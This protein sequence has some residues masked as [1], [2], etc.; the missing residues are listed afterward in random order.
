MCL[1]TCDGDCKGVGDGDGAGDDDGDGDIDID[2]DND[3]GVLWVDL[4]YV[5]R[6]TSIAI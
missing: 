3:G 6:M 5:V 1:S 4:K 2:G